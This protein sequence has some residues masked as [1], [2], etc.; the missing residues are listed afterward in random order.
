MAV[1]GRARAQ[2]LDQFISPNIAGVGIE[3][4]V[5]VQSRA[6][7]D[8]DSSGVRLGSFVL[9]PNLMES[10]G[11]E[12]NVLGTSQ[13][14]GSPVVR[15]NGEVTAD[16]DMSDGTVSAGLTVDDMRYPDQQ[17]ASYTNWTARLGGSHEFGRDTLSAQY[18]HLNLNQTLLDLDVPQGLNQSLAYRIDLGR[19]S[20]R[21]TFNRLAV[22]PTLEVS[23]YSFDNGT[24]GAGTVYQ[25]DY[26]NRVLLSPS[27]S[28]TYELAPRRNLVAVLRDSQAVYS[29]AP[30][31]LTRRDYSDVSA[32]GG[33]SYDLTGLLTVRALVGYEVRSFNSAAY[34]TISAP[35]AELAVVWTP[36][37]LTTVTGTV[38]RHIQDSSDETTAGYTETSVGVRVDHEY[39]RNVLLQANAAFY[40]DDYRGGGNQSLYAVGTGATYLLNRNVSA[41]VGYDFLARQSTNGAGTNL[42][43]TNATN[44]VL[45]A[46]NGLG[47]TGAQGVGTGAL[48]SSVGSFGNSYTDH[49]ILFQLRLRL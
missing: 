36:T 44:N 31:G 49:R 25:Q 43:A 17:R 4:G 30:P 11:Y 37:G 19:L 42:G 38:A 15:T 40:Q 46:I 20:Y 28:A 5:T 35:V 34:K 2:L 6:R 26:R 18:L 1:P 29:R 27:V 32:L 9:R 22:T 23:N 12:S 48:G 16:S 14:R 21:A 3:P 33:A 7:P 45:A 41:T 13:A 8:Y 39:R 47:A 24:T 10:A